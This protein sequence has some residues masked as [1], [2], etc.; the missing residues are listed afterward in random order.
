MPNPIQPL[1][2]V[3]IDAQGQSLGRVASLVAI[4]LRGKLLPTFRP[5]IEPGIQVEVVNVGKLRFTGS[6]LDTKSYHRF[7]GYPGGLKTTSLR[8]EFTRNP[9]RL[10]RRAVEHMLPKNRLSPRL[11][12]NLS[13]YVAES[14]Q[15]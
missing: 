5:N 15:K 2:R 14:N 13:A 9:L 3:I 6:K 12:K 1:Q 4:T 7:S 11:M 8:Q 10:F